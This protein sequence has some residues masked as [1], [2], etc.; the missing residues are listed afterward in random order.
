M[1]AVDKDV[2]VTAVERPLV[3]VGDGAGGHRRSPQGIGDV[4]DPPGGDARQVHLGDGLLDRGLAPAV[5]LDDGRL[6]GRP[7]ELRHAWLD[8]P[9]ARGEPPRVM[10]AAVGLPSRRPLVAPGPDQLRR[11]LVE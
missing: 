10:A 2:G 3:G 9:G 11:L 8:F 6:E 4:L 7:A 1:D 5:S